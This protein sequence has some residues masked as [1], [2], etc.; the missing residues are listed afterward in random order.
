MVIIKTLLITLL[1]LLGACATQAPELDYSQFCGEGVVYQCQEY[2]FLEGVERTIY[3]NGELIECFD[4]SDNP[5]CADAL[6]SSCQKV[7][8]CDTQVKPGYTDCIEPRPEFC[9]EQYD[10][11][12]ADVD[13]GIRCITEPCPST[14]RETYSNACSACADEKVY[15]YV[16]GECS[17]SEDSLPDDTPEV[18]KLSARCDDAPDWVRDGDFL[19]NYDCVESCPQESYSTQIG[20]EVCIELL[21][22]EYFES[23]PKC[24]ESSSTCDCINPA[25]TTDNQELDLGFRCVDNEN[26]K[27]RMIHYSGLCRLDENGDESCMI[28]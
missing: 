13:T 27:N 12:C 4:G 14:E 6:H 16:P 22:K 28:A 24:T 10:P 7:Y 18:G 11:V 9:T 3:L 15:G 8:E 23:L 21:D 20:L 1:I 2:V 26:Y 5:L 17:T 19:E 25:S